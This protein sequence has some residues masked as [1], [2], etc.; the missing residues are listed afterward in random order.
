MNM[1]KFARAL[2]RGDE[3]TSLT[4]TPKVGKKQIMILKVVGK[5]V[6]SEA[7][8]NEP[9]F[10]LALCN[11]ET[12]GFSLANRKCNICSGNAEQVEGLKLVV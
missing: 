4:E 12:P 11:C 10:K 8:P 6:C 7:R 9:A 1:I 3:E 5:L 2:S